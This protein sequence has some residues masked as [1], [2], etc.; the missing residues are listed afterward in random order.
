MDVLIDRLNASELTVLDKIGK[1]GQTVAQMARPLAQ[2]R[3]LAHDR[4]LQFVWNS[5][6]F[7]HK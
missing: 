2:N 7:G 6:G 1:G 3:P 5:K 4:K